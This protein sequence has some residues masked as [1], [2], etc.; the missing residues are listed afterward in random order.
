MTHCAA[1]NEDVAE[2]VLDTLR[3]QLTYNVYPFFDARLRSATRPK[4]A[5]AGDA[6]R[7]AAEDS[8]AAGGKRKPAKKGKAVAELGIK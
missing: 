8:A 2:A 1:Y 5:A 3:F 4:L 6:A 7:A